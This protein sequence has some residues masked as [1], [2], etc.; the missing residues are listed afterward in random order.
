MNL[1]RAEM[2]VSL[3]KIVNARPECEARVRAEP[4]ERDPGVPSIVERKLDADGNDSCS[5]PS[6]R[7]ALAEQLEPTHHRFTA[8]SSAAS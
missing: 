2:T 5:H 6:G 3:E 8:W 7:V 4:L 1:G